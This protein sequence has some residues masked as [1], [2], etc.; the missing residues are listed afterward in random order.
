MGIVGFGRIGQATGR[1]AKALGM[2]VIANDEY[3]NDSGREIAEY[4]TR[5]ELFARSDV[6]A[7]HCP[8]F[9]STQAGEQ[10][11]YRKDERRRDHYQ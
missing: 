7:L 10:G 3:P 5:D 2:K 1:I 9:P 11:E 6:I 4:V 8:L